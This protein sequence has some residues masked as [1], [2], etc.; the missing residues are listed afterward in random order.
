[1]KASDSFKIQVLKKLAAYFRRSISSI[2]GFWISFDIETRYIMVPNRQDAAAI[3]AMINNIE[4]M[5]YSPC[6]F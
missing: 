2:S 1:M 5:I 4:S 3:P 6:E